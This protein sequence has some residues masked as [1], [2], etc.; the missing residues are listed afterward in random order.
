M[1]LSIT[2]EE[3]TV[4][5]D[6]TQMHQTLMNLCANA[7]YAMRET[8]GILEIG[9]DHVPVDDAFAARH[10]GLQAGPYIRMTVRDTG[11]GMPSEVLERIFDPFYTTKGVGEGTGMGLAIVHGLVTSHHGAITVESTL[12]QGTSFAIYLPSYSALV[13]DIE[14]DQVEMPRGAG[15]ILFVDDEPALT[16][17]MSYLLEM[18]GYEVTTSTSSRDALEIFCAHAAD[19][20]LVMT[21]QTMPYI[22]GEGLINEVRR[23]RP[24]IPIVLCTGFSH[25][26]DAEKAQALGIDAFCVKPLEV[27]DLA[28]ILQ[29]V[30]Q[31]RSG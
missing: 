11:R 9:V 13:Q 1:R 27:R 4:L 7:E 6:A 24:D 19:F 20:D 17:A 23:I 18:L 21:D 29:Q 14:N 2:T 5:A 25:T 22:T 12:G 28:I 10:A 15:R 3:A 31:K 26:M 30:L 16:S 8:G